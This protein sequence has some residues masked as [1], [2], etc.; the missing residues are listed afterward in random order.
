MC[1]VHLSLT[2]GSCLK[3]VILQLANK[4][5]YYYHFTAL[6]LPV[7]NHRIYFEQFYCL[8]TLADRN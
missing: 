8:R 7:N 6:A 2:Y 1:H 5:W 3:I 4:Y